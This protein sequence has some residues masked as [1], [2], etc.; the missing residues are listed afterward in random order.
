M[1]TEWNLFLVFTKRGKRN[2]DVWQRQAEHF[3]CVEQTGRRTA[4]AAGAV[5]DSYRI[6][7]HL[8]ASDS[9]S[10]YELYVTEGSTTPPMS[11]ASLLCKVCARVRVCARNA[12]HLLQQCV[13]S[14]RPLSPPFSLP[15]SFLW[16]FSLLINRD[17]CN[18]SGFIELPR[19]DDDPKCGQRVRFCMTSIVAIC[20]L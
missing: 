12:Q 9:C 1:F 6:N 5:Q 20:I 19:R 7:I 16:V 18:K 2:P 3:R 13:T 4:E 17:T 8:T 14:K 11:W 15:L 10:P